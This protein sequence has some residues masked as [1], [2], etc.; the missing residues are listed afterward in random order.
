MMLMIQSLAT[1]AGAS[2]LVAN[3]GKSEISFCNMTD[4][5]KAEILSTSG[6]KEGSL[7]F[8]YLGIKVG[9]KKLSVD[10][11]HLLIDKIV[12]RIRTWGSRTMSYAGRTQLVHSVLLSLHQYWAAIFLIPNKVLEGVEAVCRNFLWDGKAVYSRAPPISWD[13]VCRPKKQGG[14]GLHD[15]Y[16]WN[17]AQKKD[18]LWLK[19]VDHQ[20]L[21]GKHWKRFKGQKNMSWNW[22]QIWKVKDLLKGGYRGDTWTANAAGYTIYSG[23]HWLHLP[24]PEVPWSNWVWNRLNIP[25]HRFI[26]WMILWRRLRVR[27]KLKQ[28]GIIQDDACPLCGVD[29]ETMDHLYFQCSYVRKC[30]TALQI[31][32]GLIGP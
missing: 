3:L 29:P 31:G 23:S 16:S 8:Q 21:K 26:S 25:K 15:C 24:H 32:T 27:T 28:F 5:L 17:I 2:G 6:F 18:S 7:P 30:C 13:L 20:Y 14:L 22:K 4:Q 11:C 12:G 10:D 9:A 19:W 1:F